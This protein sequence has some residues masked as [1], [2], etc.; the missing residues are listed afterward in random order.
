MC[1]DSVLGLGNIKQDREGWVCTPQGLEPRGDIISD[2]E[3]WGPYQKYE[4]RARTSQDNDV[5]PWNWLN[6]QM[7]SQI[8]T[9]ILIIDKLEYFNGEYSFQWEIQSISMGKNHIIHFQ[10]FLGKRVIQSLFSQITTFSF[11]LSP[12][13]HPTISLKQNMRCWPD[14]IRFQSC[15]FACPE[16]FKHRLREPLMRVLIKKLSEMGKQITGT[17]QPTLPP[18]FLLPPPRRQHYKRQGEVSHQV[19]KRH[20]PDGSVFTLPLWWH[21]SCFT[22]ALKCCPNSRR[23]LC[24]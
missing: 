5:S 15:S 14:A 19:E 16:N 9:N 22:A 13:P 1:L 17:A 6:K 23:A 18:S 7:L 3:W 24:M 8:H 11:I 12:R 20:L 2:A 10:I 21:L 4:S